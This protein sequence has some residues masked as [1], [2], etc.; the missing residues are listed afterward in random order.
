LNICWK[1]LTSKDNKVV[2]WCLDFMQVLF[3]ILLSTYLLL[4]LVETIFEGSVSS[5]LNLNYLLTLVIILGIAVVLS[6]SVVSNS[7]TLERF[8]NRNKFLIIST[9]I[10]AAVI[11]WYKTQDIG[12]ISYIISIAGG[13]L[14]VFLTVLAWQEDEGGEIEEEDS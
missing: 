9:G 14:I 6:A 13:G 11:I 8:T 1:S 7:K 12:W 2:V 10:G 3:P 5:Y 4:T